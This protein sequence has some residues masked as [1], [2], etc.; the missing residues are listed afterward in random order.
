MLHLIIGLLVST[1]L[2]TFHRIAI[3]FLSHLIISD[4]VP[5]VDPEAWNFVARQRN[6]TGKP[7]TNL[8]IGIVDSSGGDQMKMTHTR[9]FFSKEASLVFAFPA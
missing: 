9:T 2:A 8:T 7:V 1:R 3:M 6:A 4:K 5:W